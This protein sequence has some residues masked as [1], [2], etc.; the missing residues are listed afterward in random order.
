M[1]SHADLS[2]F[3]EPALENV[4][5][6]DTLCSLSSSSVL[7]VRG[8]GTPP[9]PPPPEEQGER[10]SG[11]SAHAAPHELHEA[12]PLTWVSVRTA[13]PCSYVCE[14]RLRVSAV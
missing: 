12:Q 2:V 7:V 8:T 14:A 1:L 5:S 4:H 11:Q 10:A 9:A 6:A 3:A 13:V